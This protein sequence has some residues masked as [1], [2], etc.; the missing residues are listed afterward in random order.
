MKTLIKKVWPLVVAF[1]YA[2]TEFLLHYF[3]IP[4]WWHP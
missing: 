4:H 2:A 3:N 1:T